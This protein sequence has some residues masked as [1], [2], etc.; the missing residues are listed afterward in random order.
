M[1]IKKEKYF[2]NK[3]DKK[4]NYKINETKILLI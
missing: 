4:R 1:V 3:I 2:D